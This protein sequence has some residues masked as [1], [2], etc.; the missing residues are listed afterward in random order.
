MT[1]RLRDMA[2]EV[3]SPGYIGRARQRAQR[4]KSP[5]NLVLIPL[6]AGL[7][8]GTAYVLF[9]IM[10]VVHTAIYPSHAGRLAEF[11]GKNI[12]L[13]SFASSFLLVVP[14]FFA[15]IPIGMILANAIARLIPA[16]R[17]I[18]D[19]EAEGIAGASFAE[20]ILALGKVAL[21]LVPVCLVLSGIGAATLR[22]LR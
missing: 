20:A 7:I 4:R 10:W 21:V 3:V 12:S 5:W 22:N 1:R 13:A 18:F 9:R 8:A 19:R 11:W 6:G 17:R 14:L 2:R 15:A 16:A